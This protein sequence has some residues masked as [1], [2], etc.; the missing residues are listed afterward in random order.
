MLKKGARC[1]KLRDEKEANRKGDH[2][3]KAF[4]KGSTTWRERSQAQ[5]KDLSVKVEERRGSKLSKGRFASI[6]L[7]SR[8]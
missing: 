5:R 3:A 1:H 4:R 2:I 8:G 6:G 7:E